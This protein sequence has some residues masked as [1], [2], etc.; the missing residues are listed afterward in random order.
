MKKAWRKALAFAHSK[1]EDAIPFQGKISLMNGRSAN[2]QDHSLE[3]VGNAANAG[4]T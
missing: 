3:K 2:G 1:T 4:R